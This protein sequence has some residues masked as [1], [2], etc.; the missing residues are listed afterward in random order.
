MKY[1]GSKNR[2]AKELL[3]IILADRK[4]GQ[5]FYDLFAG[6]LNIIDKVDGNRIANDIHPYLI[7]MFRE[8]QKGWIPPLNVTN[9]EWRDIRDNKEKYPKHL[10]GYVG[11]NSYGARFFEGYRRD[12]VG[13]RDYW[14]EHYNNIMK[15]LPNI[16]TITFINKSYDEVELQLNSI[17]YCDIPYKSTKKY[18][19]GNFDYDKFYQWCIEKHNEGH[20]V[21]ISEYYMP[22]DFK[23]VWQKE[24]NS[25]LTKDT[26]SK[27][28]VEKLFIVK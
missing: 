12:K 25:S 19:T 21:F 1:Q 28:N 11:F 18:S 5:Y 27:K 7:P 15:Q 13:K 16:K 6:G 8:L 24:V 17:L 20:Q 23:C 14:K 26:G 9:E 22:S 4:E 10:V 2:H 3:P